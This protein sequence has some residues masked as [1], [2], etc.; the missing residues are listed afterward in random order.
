MPSSSKRDSAL[1][2]IKGISILFVIAVHQSSFQEWTTFQR[3]M[4]GFPFWIDMA[5][6]LFMMISGY[7]SALSFERRG[8]RTIEDAYTKQYLF[9]SAIRYTVPLAIA[10][11]VEC[12][13]ELYQ[14]NFDSIKEFA[15]T[16]FYGF[17]RGGLG[18]GS[19]Y[20][21]VLMQFILLS[22]IIYF[23]IRKYK[24]KGLLGCFVANFVFEAMKDTYFIEAAQY[25]LLIFRYIF[26]I[27]I[28]CY[29]AMY[30]NAINRKVAILSFVVG[31]IF[32]VATAYCGYSPV[33]FY[34]WT[35]TCMLTALYI[36]PVFWLILKKMKAWQIHQPL[37]EV[38]G[39]S[40]YNIML[41]QMV[42]FMYFCAYTEQY[43]LGYFKNTVI[44]MLL[45][46][47]LGIALT[48]L[49]KP[50]LKWLTIKAIGR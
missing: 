22:P 32:I 39:R 45:C 44:A 17:F 26:L 27:A 40:T 35:S 18:P 6:P 34:S 37:L 20:Y 48:S 38:I 7:V 31:I 41:V 1:D 19:Y 24:G 14:H 13:I 43:G 10:Y 23:V 11:A 21:P 2:I 33:I 50:L 29:V 47:C 42:Y 3:N 25:R 9:K 12:L 5:V 15:K 4:L 46:V 30:P 16:V 8:L 28:G 36:G 49:E